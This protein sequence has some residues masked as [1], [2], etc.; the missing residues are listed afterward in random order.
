MLLAG[1]KDSGGT[2]YTWGD[3]STELSPGQQG[4][5][6][7]FA[8]RGSRVCAPCTACSWPGDASGLVFGTSSRNIW[9]A[10]TFCRDRGGGLALGLS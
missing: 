5:Q 10:D 7:A 6:P 2:Q 3:K 4:R 9:G 8:Q 1:S